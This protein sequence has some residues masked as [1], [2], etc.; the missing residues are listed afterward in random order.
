VKDQV[1]KGA[2]GGVGDPGSSRFPGSDRHRSGLASGERLHEMEATPDWGCDQ[3]GKRE[4]DGE[5][6]AGGGVGHPGSSHFSGSDR[7]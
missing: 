6:V 1:E 5:K 7:H 2:G 4:D 3:L